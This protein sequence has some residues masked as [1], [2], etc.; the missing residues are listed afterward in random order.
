MHQTP[1]AAAVS[2]EVWWRMFLLSSYPG[3]EQLALSEKSE[4]SPTSPTNWLAEINY[5]DVV[6]KESCLQ[7]CC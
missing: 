1:R 7:V 4:N 2:Y 5:S 3:A 6:S